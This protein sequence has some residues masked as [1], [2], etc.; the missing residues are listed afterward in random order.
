MDEYRDALSLELLS[1][2][3]QAE[4]TDGQATNFT[5]CTLASEL[6]TQGRN[7]EAEPLVR[8]VLEVERETL[9][10]Q[11]PST[12]ATVSNLGTLL[13]AKGKY[14]EAEPLLREVLE[15]WRET[16]GNRHPNTLKAI[17]C[18]NELLL[19]KGL[20]RLAAKLHG[21]PR[22]L[23]CGA[24]RLAVGTRA[25]SGPRSASVAPSVGC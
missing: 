22:R 15:V 2:R 5:L 10:N 25:R 21:A 20:L 9:G 18:L 12:L 3:L 6:H 1:A 11:H 23:M 14:E 19:A 8:E 24:R 4:R 16:L 13:V 7:D 17:R